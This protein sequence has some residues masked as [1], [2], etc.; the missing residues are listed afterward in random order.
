M[1]LDTYMVSQKFSNAAFRELA[2]PN[3]ML[4]LASEKYVTKLLSSM[5]KGNAWAAAMGSLI[6]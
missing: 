4:P 1:A 2:H 3:D 6:I 5:G